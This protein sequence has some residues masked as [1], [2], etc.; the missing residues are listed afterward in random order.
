M[1]AMKK[2]GITT[3]ELINGV[4]LLAKAM[5]PPD[6]SDIALIR[7]NPS[8]SWLQKRRLIRQIRKSIK[9]QREAIPW[10]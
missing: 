10:E 8:L 2:A 7:L 4:E 6:E 5:K 9:K 1:D 3:D